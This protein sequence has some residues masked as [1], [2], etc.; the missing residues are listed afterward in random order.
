MNEVFRLKRIIL[1]CFFILKLLKV[2]EFGFFM[3][4]LIFI[5]VLKNIFLFLFVLLIVFFGFWG[6]GGKVSVGKIYF[7]GLLYVKV[8][9]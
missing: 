4:I 9:S 3:L 2:I 6:V 7:F 5:K 8:N 1:K